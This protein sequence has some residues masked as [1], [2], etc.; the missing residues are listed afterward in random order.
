MLRRAA[1]LYM[2]EQQDCMELSL[3]M[4]EKPAE[5]WSRFVGRPMWVMLWWASATNYLIK[6]KQMRPSSGKWKSHVHMFWSS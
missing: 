1:V 3:G 6:K 5:S 2:R 4:V